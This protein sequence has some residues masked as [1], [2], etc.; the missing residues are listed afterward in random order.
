MLFQEKEENP[1]ARARELVSHGAILLDVRG[2]EEFAAGHLEGARNI[3]VQDLLK[4]LDELGS[5]DRPVV[6]YCR[7]GRRSAVAR[8]LLTACGFAQVDDVGG[9]DGFR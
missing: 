5:R 7:S 3:P 1:I 8:S 9:I 2:P 4:R 6:V